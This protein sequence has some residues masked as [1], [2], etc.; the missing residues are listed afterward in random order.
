MAST[1][2]IR[3]D[4]DRRTAL[5]V[6]DMINPLDFEGADALRPH[7]VDAARHIAALARRARAAG[8]PVIYVNDNFMHW[9]ADFREIVA[10]VREGTD[11]RELAELLAPEPGDYFVLKPKHSG[12]LATPLEILLEKLEVGNVLVSGVATDGCILATATDAHMREYGVHVPGDCVA[13]ITAERSRRALELMHEAMHIDV[14]GAH[15]ALAGR[16]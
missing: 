8:V 5:L 9:Q 11:G 3:D 6:V 4:R 13:A 15:T 1:S 2:G 10:E 14:S 16:G 7:A 12:F